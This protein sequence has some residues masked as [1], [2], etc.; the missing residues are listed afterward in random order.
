MSETEGGERM[1]GSDENEGE[2]RKLF[3]KVIY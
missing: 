3:F 1:N 2:N